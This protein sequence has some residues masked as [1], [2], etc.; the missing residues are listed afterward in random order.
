MTT[1]Q[2]VTGSADQR[3]ASV[4]RIRLAA[5]TAA[6]APRPDEDTVVHDRNGARL[7]RQEHGKRLS[8]SA[9]GS[10]EPPTS[11][12]RASGNPGLGSR[13]PRHPLV[14]TSATD[15]LS[16]ERWGH[17]EAQPGGCMSVI[18]IEEHWIT[19]G[20][21]GTTGR[22]GGIRMRAWP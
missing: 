2:I 16:T 6:A 7:P 17:A 13:M 14:A 3:R 15:G 9:T 1:R 8:A 22:A 20:I 12:A 11:H 5:S 4:T 21:S 19:E 10:H 18:A